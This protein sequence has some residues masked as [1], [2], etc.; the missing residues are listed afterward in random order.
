M[1]PT[2][3]ASIQIDTLYICK[4][5]TAIDV[6]KVIHDERLKW[7]ANL[8]GRYKLAGTRAEFAALELEREKVGRVFEN[9]YSEISIL[10][11]V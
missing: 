5:V 2:S 7:L 11:N 1:T 3:T 9:L 4:P 10:F 8:E 6:T